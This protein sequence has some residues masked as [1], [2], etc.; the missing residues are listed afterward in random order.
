MDTNPSVSASQGSET[1]SGDSAEASGL[2]ARTEQIFARVLASDTANAQVH[3]DLTRE[4]SLAAE[5]E[6]SH[7]IRHPIKPGSSGFVNTIT[8]NGVTGA[9]LTKVDL[10]S[11]LSTN[12]A[13]NAR[14]RPSQRNV[15]EG[16]NDSQADRD[17]DFRSVNPSSLASRPPTSINGPTPSIEGPRD[18]QSTES[19]TIEISTEPVGDNSFAAVAGYPRPPAATPKTSSRRVKQYVLPDGSVVSGKG[20]GRG[21]PGIKRGPRN[22][23]Y[24]IVADTVPQPPSTP[25]TAGPSTALPSPGK[26]RKRADSE[27]S[28]IKT[29]RSPSGSGTSSSRESSVE[30]NPTATQTR[31][32][33]YT[34][35]P[36]SLVAPTAASS[37]PSTRT[38][39]AS[40]AHEASPSTIRTH[41]KIKRRVYRGRE[42]FA[43]CD[44]CLRGHGPPGNVIVFCDA[45]NKC[46][47]QRCHDPQV[48]KQVVADTKAEWFC[49]ECDRILHGNKKDKK[50]PAKPSPARPVA[51]AL[52]SVPATV[53]YSGILVGGAALTS[54][55][56]V[57]YLN[58]LTK[59]KLMSLV[60][61]AADLAPHLP[62]FQTPV[63][64]PV[65]P[66]AQFTSTYVTPVSKP[67]AF[68][69]AN[70]ASPAEIAD[71]GY[72]DYFD[73]HAALY[74]KPGNG[75]QLPPESVDMH[76]LLEGKDCRTFSHWVKGT[77]GRDYSDSGNIQP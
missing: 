57:A 21:R 72:D 48:P 53:A 69:A 38:N 73:E 61:Q 51:Q 12:L 22:P 54:D 28:N 55:Q 39:S 2:P 63:L 41:P 40:V 24:K 32:G 27:S 50:P 46:W 77:V 18:R 4:A 9:L 33:R 5:T 10:Q 20:L 66:Q 45:C 7:T 52:P 70:G 30:Y 49:T 23:K 35:K 15:E 17:P 75:L 68:A 44:H 31:S 67:P 76:M 43:L 19:T 3:R 1:N 13:S 74:P 11:T 60:L 25:G 8:D 16:H 47:H 59:D 37:S 34:Q 56:K 65:P 42:Q 71:E 58:T 14:M 29:R 64:A 62:L 36:P 6:P 26:K